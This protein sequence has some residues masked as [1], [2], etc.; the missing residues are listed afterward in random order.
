MQWRRH[1]Q[2]CKH[3][4]GE[5]ILNTYDDPYGFESDDLV[6]EETRMDAENTDK[7]INEQVLLSELEP[8]FFSEVRTIGR[9][10]KGTHNTRPLGD[11]IK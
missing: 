8:E 10:V 6:D 3:L 11:L 1:K 7:L 2:P 9:I 4:M 5:H